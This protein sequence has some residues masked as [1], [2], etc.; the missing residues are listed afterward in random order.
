MLRGTF[1]KVSE[2]TG[3]LWGS[4][5]KPR[6]ETYDVWEMPEDGWLCGTGSLVLRS[7]MDIDPHFVTLFLTSPSTVNRLSDDSVGAT[8]R[9]LNQR[10]MVN[11]PF[12]LPPLAEQHPIVARVDQ[13]MGLLDRL[14]EPAVRIHVVYYADT[15][16]PG[17]AFHTRRVSSSTRRSMIF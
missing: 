4:G 6:W 1:W 17:W 14:E 7:S 3:Y 12:G 10:I 16:S 11:L 5:F 13:L 15:C 8:M 2:R 9:N